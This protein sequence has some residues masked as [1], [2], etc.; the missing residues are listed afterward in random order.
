MLGK[1][2]PRAIPCK[3]SKQQW[4]KLQEWC[5]LGLL[6]EDSCGQTSSN[7]KLLQLGH[8][9]QLEME[10]SQERES[11]ICLLIPPYLSLFVPHSSSCTVPPNPLPVS[12]TLAFGQYLPSIRFSFLLNS[13]LCSFWLCQLLFT[14]YHMEN[15]GECR[16]LKLANT[17]DG[18]SH[19]NSRYIATS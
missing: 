2:N 18:R 19:T 3:V 6:Q 15:L 17:L 12:L 14:S 10:D 13:S 1:I 11:N 8:V 9:C 5:W 7:S 4:K 16:A